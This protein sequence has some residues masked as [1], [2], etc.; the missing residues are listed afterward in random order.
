MVC[1]AG[2][3]LLSSPT[4]TVKKF[5]AAAKKGD[6]EAMTQLFSQQAVQVLGIERIRSKNEQFAR[7]ARAANIQDGKFRMEGLQETTTSIGKRVSFV[8]K[9]ENGNDSIPLVFDLEEEYGKWKIDGFSDGRLEDESTSP[10]PTPSLSDSI[11]EPPPPFPAPGIANNQT[12]S[13]GKRAPISGGVL[14]G[15]AISL[16]KPAY[17]P[18]AQAAKASG[19]V[20]VHVIVDENGNVTS[21]RAISGHPLLQ[22]S[23]V[24]AA[25]AAKFNPTKLGGEPVKVTGLITFQFTPE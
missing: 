8:Y 20:V 6:A 25:R 12:N 11:T 18:V 10:S 22:A 16:P 7:T 15:K 9:S 19:T 4:G 21:A 17:P 13:A 5:M 14:N 1:L 2:C 3:S 23:A 24:A